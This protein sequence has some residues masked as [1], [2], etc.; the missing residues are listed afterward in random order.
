VSSCCATP[1]DGPR[2]RGHP[3]LGLLLLVVLRLV[4]GLTAVGDEVGLAVGGE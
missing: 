4:A 1:S 3:S 2:H